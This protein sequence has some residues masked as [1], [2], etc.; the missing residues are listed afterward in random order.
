[1]FEGHGIKRWYV[2]VPPLPLPLL[3]TNGRCRLGG[4]DHKW[5]C[6]NRICPEGVLLQKSDKKVFSKESRAIM[7]LREGF[8]SKNRRSRSFPPGK[9]ASKTF[10]GW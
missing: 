8:G 4:G 1:M 7:R 10:F 9:G 5:A 2:S 3:A 6:S